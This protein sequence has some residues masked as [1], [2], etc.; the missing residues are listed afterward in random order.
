METITTHLI[1]ETERR[2]L[3]ESI[4]RIKQSLGLLTV[5]QIWERPNADMASIGHLVLHVCG[6]ARQW[7]LH[8]LCGQP[9]VR[10]R[11]S[12]FADQE[13]LTQEELIRLLDELASDLQVALPQVQETMLLATYPVQVFQENGVAILVHAI[14]HFS[15]H[16][17]Q[18]ARD[19][20]RMLRIDLGFYADL[21][22]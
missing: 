14:E 3:G 12:E 5:E 11:Q 6:N 2:I 4:P 19:T 22:L 16:A 10:D 13:P 15:Y 21:D 8:A 9:D 7:V 18:I 20:K 17:G 1:R